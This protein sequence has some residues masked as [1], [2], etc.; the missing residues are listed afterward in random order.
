MSSRKKPA[1]NTARAAKSSINPMGNFNVRSDT[2]RNESKGT[3]PTCEPTSI[4]D[5]LLTALMH[6]CKKTIFY[7]V[8]L[9]VAIYLL[10]LFIVSLIGGKIRKITITFTQH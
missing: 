7:D 5:V 1:P 9:K 2:T 3:K 4:K 6:L 8:R 10:S